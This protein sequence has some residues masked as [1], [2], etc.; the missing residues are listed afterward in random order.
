MGG[1]HYVSLCLTVS[2]YVSLCCYKVCSCVVALCR[3]LGRALGILG[4]GGMLM[5]GG[6]GGEGRG[7]EG[8]EGKGRPI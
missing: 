3:V 4:W 7:G 8:M 6:R 5:V 1:A 2:H